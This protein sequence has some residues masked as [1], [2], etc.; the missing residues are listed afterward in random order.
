MQLHVLEQHAHWAPAQHAGLP[1]A[2][3]Q[4]TLRPHQNAWLP[5][6]PH[7]IEWINYVPGTHAAAPPLFNPP[8]GSAGNFLAVASHAADI[9]L[10]SGILLN[11]DTRVNR[12]YHL[13]AVTALSWL[14]YQPN[15]LASGSR[16]SMVKIWDLNTLR[17]VPSFVRHTLPRFARPKSAAFAPSSDPHAFVSTSGGLILQF[18]LR[19]AAQHV[20]DAT[21]KLWDVFAGTL[22]TAP[23]ATFDLSTHFRGLRV[24]S[25]CPDREGVLAVGGFDGAAVLDI[26]TGAVTMAASK[27]SH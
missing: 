17:P 15:L 2:G 5:S 9:K 26:N 18:D 13:D 12:E 23:T 8:G 6:A 16:D 7:A 4:Y 14:P 24:C 1:G 3:T 10:W 11:V 20:G 25:W 27:T 22:P 19:N 21:V